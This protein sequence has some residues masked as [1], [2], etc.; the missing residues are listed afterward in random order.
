MQGTIQEAYIELVSLLKDQLARKDERIAMLEAQIEEAN[1]HA[2]HS[3]SAEGAQ[4]NTVWNA[5]NREAISAPLRLPDFGPPNTAVAQIVMEA[6]HAP[7]AIPEQV[8]TVESTA[9]LEKKYLLQGHRALQAEAYPRRRRRGAL[10]G[11][12]ALAAGVLALMPLYLHRTHIGTAPQTVEPTVEPPVLMP[13]L[14]PRLE[15]TAAAPSPRILTPPAV[16]A[17]EPTERL[18]ESPIALLPAETK[19]AAPRAVPQT[20]AVP[21]PKPIRQATAG[22]RPSPARALR[23]PHASSVSNRIARRE[24]SHPHAASASPLRSP[25]N[26]EIRERAA[27]SSFASPAPPGQH[28]ETDRG[29]EDL[30]GLEPSSRYGI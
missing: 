16:S 3:F 13:P 30:S 8:D 5:P 24:R 19:P 23:T 10:L 7:V 9:R 1:R 21:P 18:A 29:I 12:G 11:I 27:D 26:E 14:P 20:R 15:P 25:S 17:P 28:E 4:E 6:A 2:G 22:V